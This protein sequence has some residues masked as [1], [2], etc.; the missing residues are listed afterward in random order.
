MQR[1]LNQNIEFY[2]FSSS[3]NVIIS[4]AGDSFESVLRNSNISSNKIGFCLMKYVFCKAVEQGHNR[5]QL[6]G[7]NSYL[8]FLT[9]NHAVKEIRSFIY[10]LIQTWIFYHLK[11]IQAS[12]ISKNYQKFTVLIIYLMKIEFL[13]KIIPKE[14]KQ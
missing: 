6:A 1:L 14:V 11:Q 12:H 10:A 13:T 8:C 3:H 2:W 9:W 5:W 7:R 4:V